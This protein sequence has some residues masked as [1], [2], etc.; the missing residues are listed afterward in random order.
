MRKVPFQIKARAKSAGYSYR[1][2]L[3]SGW[4]FIF[5]NYALNWTDILLI[6]LCGNAVFLSL[7]DAVYTSVG[8][9]SL[10]KPMIKFL[11]FWFDCCAAFT[12]NQRLHIFFITNGP[13]GNLLNK[14]SVMHDSGFPLQKSVLWSVEYTVDSGTM[15][16]LRMFDFTLDIFFRNKTNAGQQSRRTAFRRFHREENVKETSSAADVSSFYFK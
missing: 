3:T 9:Q 2:I 10:G 6:F 7:S 15:A 11:L 13:L 14:T 12:W 4:S 8:V 1:F 16:H 5:L